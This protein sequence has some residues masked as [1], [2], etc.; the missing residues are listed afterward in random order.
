MNHKILLATL[1]FLTMGQLKAQQATPLFD[2]DIPRK[3]DREFQFL[4]F[5]INQ[6][7]TSN[8]FPTT[9]FLR[10]QVI[11]RMFGR[12]TTM[13]S[14]T[15]STAYVEQRLIPFFIY[16]P[17]LFNG[18]ATLRAAFE[19]D[20]TWGDVSYGAG[21][22]QGGAVSGHQVNIQTQNIELELL[23]APGWMI[24][25]GLQR[26]YD[27]PYNPYR[28]T[29][30]KLLTSGYR[31]NYFGT[32]AVGITLYR[33][34]DFHRF[35]AG[36]FK[37][38]ENST[39]K[40]DDVDMYE[41]Q[42]EAHI[43]KLWK[44]ALTAHF[45]RDRGNGDGGVSILGQGLNSQLTEYNGVFR[46]RYGSSPYKADIGWIGTHFSR[47]ADMML[48]RFFM[49]GYFNY[50][51]G[52]VRVERGSGFKLSEDIFGFAANLRLGYR[53][54]QTLQDNVNMEL[55]Y[56]SGDD[57]GLDDKRY[58]GVITGNTWAAPGGIYI[59]SGAYLLFAHGNVVNRF[60]PVV[61]DLSNMGYG[62]VAAVA[63]YNRSI[64]PHRFNVKAGTAT[65]ISNV[66]PMGGGKF[67]GAEI[68]GALMY[69]LGPFMS[70]ELHGAYMWLGDFF[71]SADSRY[72]APVN[73]GLPGVRP[74]NPWT[75]FVVYKWLMF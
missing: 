13:T 60:T 22:N 39:F 75:M 28:T 24:N 9:D 27:T 31:L 40:D 29:V 73:G 55:I 63:N 10:G 72:S 58:S 8:F 68:N 48:D 65:A 57:D 53:Y 35:K 34:A 38:Y 25:L 30:D 51:L 7:V 54:G 61:S 62:L 56:A 69:N 4:A 5:Y 47:N 1:L 50:N 49:S 52:M 18:K 26:M 59:N 20:W 41:F 16:Q 19:I 42:Y 36:W 67:L 74:S 43:N 3:A 70:I 15:A 37:F 23:P 11:G 21:G 71:D 33:D 2:T 44:A 66:A 6:G 14:D 32:Q 17:N 46:F 64:I 45:V 12:N